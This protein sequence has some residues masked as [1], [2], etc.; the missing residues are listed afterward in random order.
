MLV[1][2]TWEDDDSGRVS[3]A[4]SSR[5]TSALGNTTPLSPS[6]IPP[7]RLA[8]PVS[9]GRHNGPMLTTNL[10]RDSAL[11]PQDLKMPTVDSNIFS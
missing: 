1:K 4:S 3:Q 10:R 9:A 5:A 7:V 11:I 6:T 2:P 8:T